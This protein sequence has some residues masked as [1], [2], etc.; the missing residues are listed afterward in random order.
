MLKVV[1]N[2]A[3]NKRVIKELLSFVSVLRCYKPFA[4]GLKLRYVESGAIQGK[5]C[6]DVIPICVQHY[7]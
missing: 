5:K 2:M 4:R 6:S 1:E 7:F 3:R